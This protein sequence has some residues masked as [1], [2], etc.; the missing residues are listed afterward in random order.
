MITTNKVC[1]STIEQAIFCI[2]EET[3]LV[4]TQYYD[5]VMMKSVGRRTLIEFPTISLEIR[6]NEMY[7]TFNGSFNRSDV[8]VVVPI[9]AM[10]FYVVVNDSVAVL[11]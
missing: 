9:V 3:V 6:T 11:Y 10:S 2:A 8:Q 7:F 5:A 1:G 4:S